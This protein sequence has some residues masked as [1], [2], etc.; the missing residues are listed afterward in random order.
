MSAKKMGKWKKA[1]P[2]DIRLPD[3]I[4]LMMERNK[5]QKMNNSAL[6]EIVT[7]PSS[8]QMDQNSFNLNDNWDNTRSL[9]S[10]NLNT[11]QTQRELDLNP[12]WGEP[13]IIE[14]MNLNHNIQAENKD[15]VS[16]ENE[17]NFAEDNNKG[18]N[19]SGFGALFGRNYRK[20]NTELNDKNNNNETTEKSTDQAPIEL[21][22]SPSKLDHNL[23]EV[24]KFSISEVNPLVAN[25]ISEADV[26]V[27]QEQLKKLALAWTDVG[28]AVAKFHTI[29]KNSI[30]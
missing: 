18:S 23:S 9:A 20:N 24:D 17:I 28:T 22:A 6:S 27:T 5:Q 14:S 29:L 4:K 11:A 26:I 21:E 10:A 19:V 2:A 15:A 16:N 12:S 8:T 1:K 13:Y 25:N 30:E 7:E 3:S